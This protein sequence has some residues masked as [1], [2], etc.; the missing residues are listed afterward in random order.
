MWS[1]NPPVIRLTRSSC[2]RPRGQ[3]R[4]ATNADRDNS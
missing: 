2:N 3:L 4:K 1:T